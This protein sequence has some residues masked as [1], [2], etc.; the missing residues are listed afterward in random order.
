M[1]CK[2]KNNQK[3][4]TSIMTTG[5]K[6]RTSVFARLGKKKMEKGTSSRQ[7]VSRVKRSMIHFAS[8]QTS[9]KRRSNNLLRTGSSHM[10]TEW[11]T[12][13]HKR[14][15]SRVEQD[16]SSDTQSQKRT[17]LSTG[18]SPHPQNR[19]DRMWGTEH[20]CLFHSD[21]RDGHSCCKV[22]NHELKT[23]AVNGWNSFTY[24]SGCLGHFDTETMGPKHKDGSQSLD[25]TRCFGHWFRRCRGG[26]FHPNNII[27]TCLE[28]EQYDDQQD[29]DKFV[30]FEH[31]ADWLD[32]K[33][34]RYRKR[35]W[36]EQYAW[37]K[38]RAK[39][40]KSFNF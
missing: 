14:V 16:D 9:S 21:G 24:C 23:R 11:E 25:S 39:Y 3:Q 12:E 15:R 19:F 40:V 34:I 33:S 4:S 7:N 20:V 5:S 37:V 17:R 31:V 13:S 28:C 26:M 1:S 29:R 30:L 32:S 27:P 38:Q 6:L 8:V 22:F 2:I 10:V 18:H 35:V 36:N